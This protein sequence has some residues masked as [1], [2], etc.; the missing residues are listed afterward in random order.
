MKRILSFIIAL[1]FLWSDIQVSF[2]IEPLPSRPSDNRESSGL[3]VLYQIYKAPDSVPAGATI[4]EAF[5]A[6]CLQPTLD[7]IDGRYDCADFSLIFLLRLYNEYSHLLPES[8]K[9][10]VKKTILGFKYWMDEPGEDSMCFW[11]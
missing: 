3:S 11:S 10:A 9:A 8:S 1:V 5:I 2:N 4:D 7:Y 6:A